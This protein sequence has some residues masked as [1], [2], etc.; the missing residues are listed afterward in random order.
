MNYIWI[1][2]AGGALAFAHCLG[3]CGGFALHF[4]RGDNRWSVLSSQLLW[5]TGKTFTY[6][7]LGALAAFG[8]GALARVPGLPWIQNLMTYVAGGII[9]LMGMALL[10][11]LPFRGAKPSDGNEESLLSSAFREFF[12]ESTRTAAFA[13]GMVTGFLPC[14]IVVSFVA[15]SAQSG[16]VLI[17]MAT[18]AAMGVGTLWSLL[19]LGMLGQFASLRVRRWSAVMGGAVLMVLGLVTILRGTEAFHR[20]LGCSF[21]QHGAVSRP[22]CHN[23]K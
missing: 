16:S 18:M 2:L 19:L 21:E 10:G 22:C 6:V 17:G 4:S 12:R 9:I 20:A 8:G 3:M 14:P 7:F 5:H 13:L 15:L 11:I 1:G 23:G